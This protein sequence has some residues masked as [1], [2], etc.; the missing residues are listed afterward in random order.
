MSYDAF[1]LVLSQLA[2]SRK[3]RVVI[4]DNV[5]FFEKSTRENLWTI[6]T[7]VYGGEGFLSPSVRE[8]VSSS[9]YLR[10]QQG[11]AYLKL[12]PQEHAV[13]LFQEIDMQEGKYIPFKYHLSDFSI[14]ANEWKEILQGQ[15]DKDFSP[16]R[17]S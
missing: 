7:K 16:I 10:W 4:Q 9:G 15:A 6:Y 1:L 14:V 2:G 8:C 5:I 13:Y 17:V 11:G 3:A 12:E